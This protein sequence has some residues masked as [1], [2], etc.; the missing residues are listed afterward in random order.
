MEPV[1]RDPI[2]SLTHLATAVLALYVTAILWRLAGRDRAKRLSLF[3]FGACAVV[4][5]GVSGIYHAIPLPRDSTAVQLFRRFDHSAI[6]LLIAG[7][8]TP[9]FAVLLR[10]RARAVLLAVVWSLAAAGIAAKWLFPIQGGGFDV[11]L[12]LAMG[13][14][15]V[16]P[17]AAIVR[18][19]GWGGLGW[20][21][22]GGFFYTAGAIFELLRWPVLIPGVLAWH[23]VFHVF[24]MAGTAL[25]VGFM[26]RCVV[27]YR[28]PAY[29]LAKA[30]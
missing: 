11:A 1:L 18:T 8:Y 3:C 12:Y 30:A 4:L 5:Y 22:G 16:L 9:V 19:V 28:R 21:A 7:T 2:S 14:L 29:R 13:W 10:G 6:Y 15:G 24:T 23:E 27:P 17:A 26:I 25:H 20:I